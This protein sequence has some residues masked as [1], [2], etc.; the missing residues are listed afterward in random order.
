[1]SREEENAAPVSALALETAQTVAVF[2]AHVAGDPSAR[3]LRTRNQL[4]A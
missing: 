3:R 2:I 1:V 4:S